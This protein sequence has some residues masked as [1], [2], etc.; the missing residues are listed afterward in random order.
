MDRIPT[1]VF[2]RSAGQRPHLD[3][4]GM[5][6]KVTDNHWIPQY[7]Y[8][9]SPLEFMHW[10]CIR[11]G[12]WSGI[13]VS[14]LHKGPRQ[15]ND[16]RNDLDLDS[17]TIFGHRFINEW[18]ISAVLWTPGTF[19][20]K[21]HLWS[22]LWSFKRNFTI[23]WVD[24]RSLSVFIY[25]S[26]GSIPWWKE[27]PFFQATIHPPVA[28]L[29]MLLATIVSIWDIQSV[30][31][32]SSCL[33]PA[34]YHWF[35]PCSGGICYW[36]SRNFPSPYSVLSSYFPTSSYCEDTGL[37]SPNYSWGYCTCE[38]STRISSQGFAH[39]FNLGRSGGSMLSMTRGWTSLY[40][41]Q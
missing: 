36:R 34:S 35:R 16:E 8:S 37:C 9:V 39:I 40:L 24:S 31:Q 4:L 6:S 30:Y 15:P 38:V 25:P 21:Y 19:S 27:Y 41:L 17:S 32:F 29:M 13:L 10:M 7:D 3:L 14:N 18:S 2:F 20:W 11:S 1:T 26:C 12:I 23:S 33:V 28:T 22:V 5:G